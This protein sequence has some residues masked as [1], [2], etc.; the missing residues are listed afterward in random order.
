MNALVE[1][2]LDYLSLERGLSANTRAAY[3]DDLTRFVHFLERKGVKSFN[4]VDR[5][6]LLDYLM[7]EKE[8]GLRVNSISR[9]LVAIKIFFRYLQ[10][11]SL[12]VRNVAEVM[13]SPK[14]WKVLPEVMSLKEVERM[15]E[16]PL[17]DDNPSIR[18]KALLELMYATGLRVSEAA[19]LKL[20]DIHFDEGYIR[21]LGK[22]S[23]VRIV[24]FGDKA[25]ICL[26]RYLA[27]ARPAYARDK[28]VRHVFLTYRGKNFSR[29]GIWK[30]IKSYARKAG[31]K[32][33][34]SPHTMR[35]SFASHL[36]ANGA[37][38]RVI[39]EML[40]HADIATTQIYTHV[41]QGRLKSVHEKF[42]PR[43]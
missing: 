22:G 14:L 38:L 43:A 11:E 30:L 24:P 18:D 29:K 37:P 32:R 13:D 35:H 36:L 5:K 28:P 25:R 7:A 42:H 9:R 33:R 16:V 41:D 31:I 1:Q 26:Q 39:Q 4:M 12:L 20:E 3:G 19:E 10:H 27:D 23:K 2:F 15:L 34:V 17:G 8:R 40:G 21:C 6:H